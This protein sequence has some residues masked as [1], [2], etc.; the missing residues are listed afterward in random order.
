[1]AEADYSQN[2]AIPVGTRISMAVLADLEPTI[3]HSL[4]TQ[5]SRF[6]EKLR[7]CFTAISENAHRLVGKESLK[8]K[9]RPEGRA[10]ACDNGSY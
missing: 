2:P 6:P 4:P 10:N 5:I 1:M 9:A 8:R 3:S 7:A